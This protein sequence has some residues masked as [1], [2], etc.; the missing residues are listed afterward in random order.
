MGQG[1]WVGNR[2]SSIHI[3]CKYNQIGNGASNLRY[4]IKQKQ[5]LLVEEQKLIAGEN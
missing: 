2:C 4:V 3:L 1:M 5:K